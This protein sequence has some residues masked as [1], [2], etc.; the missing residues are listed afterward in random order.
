MGSNFSSCCRA[1]N[2]QD[3]STELVFHDRRAY[4]FHKWQL[5]LEVEEGAERPSVYRLRQ[6]LFADE[7]GDEEGD[8]IQEE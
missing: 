3:R 2:N 6:K 1:G 4:A 5:D 8:D 7:M